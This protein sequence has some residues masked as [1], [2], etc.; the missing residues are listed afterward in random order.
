[1]FEYN[2]YCCFETHFNTEN[3]KICNYCT[4]LCESWVTNIF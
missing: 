1:M 4:T 2:S 3:K